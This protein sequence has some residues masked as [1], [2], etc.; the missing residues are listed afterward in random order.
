VAVKRKTVPYAMVDEKRVLPF[1]RELELASLLVLAEARRKRDRPSSMARVYYPLHILRWEGGALLIDLLRLNHTSIKYDVIPKVDEFERVLDASSEEPDAFR[2]ALRSKG[3][4]FKGFAGHKTVRINGLIVQRGK[5][6]EL[7][8]FLG[9]MYDFEPVDEPVIFKPVLKNGDI[10][11]IIASIRSLREDIEGDLKLLERA[12]RSMMGALDIARKVLNE[13]IQNIRD[14]ST[15]VKAPMRKEFEKVKDRRRRALKLELGKVRKEYRKQAT[16][17]RGERTKLKGK[18]AR[19][20][21]KLDLL[22]A[23]KESAVIENISREIKEFEVEFEKV[24]SAIRS[25]ETWRDAEVKK[26]RTQCNGAIKSEADKI[27]EEDARSRDEVQKRKAEISELETE[28]KA[29]ASNINSLI[30]SKNGKL[31]S[32]SG[33]CFDIAAESTD[34]YVPFYI[35]QY[36]EKFDF[37][38]PVVASSAKG[39]LS[40]FKRML[41][42]NLQS[43]M[44]QLIKPRTDFMDKYLAKAVKT[45]GRST[46]LASEYR[47]A[48]DRL[49]LLRSREAVDKIM[50][51][52]VRIHREGWISEGEYIRLQEFLVDN[53]GLISRP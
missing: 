6:E 15:K 44:T 14:R 24:D 25:L 16:P 27:K 29:V 36:G 45:L 3:A 33:L 32:I 22:K 8:K 41:A 51:G 26:A 37:Y 12:K 47:R 23:D 13:E 1:T 21:K 48:G 39:F 11:S 17:L 18:L 2:K 28:V 42:E 4:R 19:R 9:N 40:R 10:K 34:L 49:N 50:V 53:L 7:S 52:L 46:T 43:K 5:S 20:R 35:F 30:R 38:P 31:R